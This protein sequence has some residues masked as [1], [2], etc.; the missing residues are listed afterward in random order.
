M[1][2][3]TDGG[4]RRVP[5]ASGDSAPATS[6]PNA[7]TLTRPRIARSIVA[8]P[9]PSEPLGSAPTGKVVESTAA[10]GDPTTTLA[11]V[12]RETS[13]TVRVVQRMDASVDAPVEEKMRNAWQNA[14]R[15]LTASV[16][17]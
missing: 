15:S 4:T 16:R 5:G 7:S 11:A 6:M 8:H 17:P 9:F 12:M 2:P 10:L 3:L 14:D 13:T 1:A